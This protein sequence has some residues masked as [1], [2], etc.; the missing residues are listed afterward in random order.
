MIVPL[1]PRALLAPLA[2]AAT[3]LALDA[4]SAAA[5]I[6]RGRSG[7]FEIV[8]TEEDIT[9]RRLR[10]GV[11][12]FSV[13][14]IVE[15]QWSEGEADT[16]EGPIEGEYRFRL[17]SVVGPVISLE[18]YGYCDCNGAHPISHAGFVA[19]DLSESTVDDPALARVTGLVSEAGL[20]EALV[21]DPVLR[22]GLAEVGGE[23]PRTIPELVHK[24]NLEDIAVGEDEC[25]YGVSDAF[26]GNF[27]LHHVDDGRVAVRFSLSHVVEVCRGQMVQVGVLVPV[28]PRFR[29]AVTAADARRAGFLMK[30]ARRV[31]GEAATI[32][33]FGGK[34]R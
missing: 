11:L 17:L 20:V 10:D 7:G 16:E 15:A 22:R 6:W 14:R 21:A 33:D 4:T 30:D 34:G 12:V 18:E 5:Q 24:L 8:W 29:D 3:F 32:I 2:L 28:R 1:R 27:A 31:G 25:T 23:A 26:P 9:A 19:Y 13:K